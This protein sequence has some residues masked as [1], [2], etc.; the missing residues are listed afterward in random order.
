MKELLLGILLSMILVGC[1]SRDEDGRK[2]AEFGYFKD[3]R[4]GMCFASGTESM[5]TVPC[6]GLVQDLITDSYDLTYYLDP[7]TNLC[8]AAGMKS[9]AH[10][11]CTP[12][13]KKLI[14]E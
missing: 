14:G 5:A 2:I 9:I 6:S 11:E 8:F 3:D 12:E 1:D 7:Q 13:I 10:V 4:V